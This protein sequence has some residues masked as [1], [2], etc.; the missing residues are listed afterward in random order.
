MIASDGY[1]YEDFTQRLLGQPKENTRNGN[2]RHHK[3]VRGEAKALAYAKGFDAVCPGGDP[4]PSRQ[5]FDAHRAGL[6]A[7]GL[8]ADHEW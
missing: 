4:G 1:E 2:V 8:T 3:Q 7:A 5:F 6:I